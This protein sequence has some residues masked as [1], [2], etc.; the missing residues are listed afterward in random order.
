MP[1][2]YNSLFFFTW[3]LIAFCCSTASPSWAQGS[4]EGD[5]KALVALYNATD[6][7]NWKNNI[8]WSADL[9]TQPTVQELDSWYG[10]RVID[11]RVIWL[12]LVDNS[13]SGTIP[14]SLGSLS[15]LKHLDLESNSLTGTI[16]TSLGN[17]S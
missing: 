12:Q 14:G 17:L 7:P 6:G 5:W 4:L 8:N 11:G 15:Q 2:R 10:V 1:I 13:L 3:G 9:T 16:P